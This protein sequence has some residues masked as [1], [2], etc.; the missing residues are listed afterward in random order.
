MVPKPRTGSGV[1]KLEVGVGDGPGVMT[2]VGTVPRSSREP[3]CRK[4]HWSKVN[5]FSVRS[6]STGMLLTSEMLSQVSPS[7]TT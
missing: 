3:T 2:A 6:V 5:P 1:G 7:L 4:R